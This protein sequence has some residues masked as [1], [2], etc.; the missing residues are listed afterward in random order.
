MVSVAS[1]VRA[2]RMRLSP[3]ERESGERRPWRISAFDPTAA[4]LLPAAKI[5][6]E[7]KTEPARRSER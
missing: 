4:L 3:T 6:L 7:R 5:V 2:G 1:E